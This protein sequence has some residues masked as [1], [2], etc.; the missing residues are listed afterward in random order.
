MAEQFSAEKAKEIIDGGLGQAQ[1]LLEDPSKIGDLLSQ[2][3]K[4]LKDV[5]VIGETV[6][7]VPLMIQMI[8]SYI[9]REYTEVSPKV[10]ATMVS[11]IL[12]L[13]SKNDIIPD[14]TPML[15][16]ADDIAIFALCLKANSEE[17]KAFAKWRDSNAG[18]TATEAE[19]VEV[20]KVDE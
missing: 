19:V 16:Y 8:K 11:A 20:Q 1:E 4:K 9:T 5:P 15:G 12:Y 7:D 10:V 17:L 13:V 2:L 14:N 3:E 18:A 6:S